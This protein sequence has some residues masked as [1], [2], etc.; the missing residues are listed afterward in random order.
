MASVP[1]VWPFLLAAAFTAVGAADVELIV[2]GVEAPICAKSSEVCEAARRAIAKGWWDLGVPA[3]TPTSC[4]PHP[5]CFDFDSN[6]IRGFNLP[7]SG[8]GRQ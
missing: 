3:A 4:Q 5:Q 1:P 8:S 2:T 6:Y 7:A